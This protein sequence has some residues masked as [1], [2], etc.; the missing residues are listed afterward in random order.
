MPLPPLPGR[1]PLKDLKEF[2]PGILLYFYFLKHMAIL[3]GSLSLIALVQ[4]II[5]G[6]GDW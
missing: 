4:V 1:C 3:F 6:L 5:Y 2:G